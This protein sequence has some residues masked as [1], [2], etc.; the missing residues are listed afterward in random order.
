[1]R[2]IIKGSCHCGAIEVEIAGPIFGFKHCHC[3]SCRK[4]H[5]TAYASN[6]IVNTE[7]FKIVK[8]EN[9]FHDYQTH[10]SKIA[11]F[12]KMCGSPI[13]AYIPASP[14]EVY[15]RMGMLDLDEDPGVVAEYHWWVSEKA[16]WYEICDGL[17]QF[18][19]SPSA[20]ELAAIRCNEDTN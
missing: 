16:P 19:S 13:Y 4:L 14:T 18:M 11:R 9:N 3:Q 8:G 2:K 15:I 17:P 12:C 1:M 5:G 20:D 10:A 7:D 6:A